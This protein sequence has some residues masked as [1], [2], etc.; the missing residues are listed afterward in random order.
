MHKR[1]AFVFGLLFFTASDGLAQSRRVFATS[2]PQV[3][4]WNREGRA[5]GQPPNLNCDQSDP[6]YAFNDAGQTWLVAANF[7]PIG[8]FVNQTPG[9][10]R[11]GVNA[12]FD[13]N[14]P[15]DIRFRASWTSDTG[16]ARSEV[17]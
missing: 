16:A 15:A 10:V 1:L 9:A 6:D 7:S 4:D 2:V 13:M 3:P 14:E 8:A 5:S 11:A 12:R 17:V